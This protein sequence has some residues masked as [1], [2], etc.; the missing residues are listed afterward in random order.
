MVGGF[1]TVPPSLTISPQVRAMFVNRK[2]DMRTAQPI[3]RVHPQA[4]GY[5]GE[6]VCSN[7]PANHP[8]TSFWPIRCAH[9]EC[10][11]RIY[12]GP[13]SSR[14]AIP[15][16][17]G[18]VKLDDCSRSTHQPVLYGVFIQNHD[19]PSAMQSAAVCSKTEVLRSMRLDECI[20]E[21]DRD[22]E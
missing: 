9:P 19:L 1:T 8:G 7:S 20:A 10:R 21:E 4:A 13:V 6:V 17:Q 15:Q 14:V 11:R 3:P 2:R 22:S 12:K 16:T 5:P 18:L